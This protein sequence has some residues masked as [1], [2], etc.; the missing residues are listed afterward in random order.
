VLPSSALRED[1]SETL[2]GSIY[3]YSL[4]D[5]S[6]TTQEHPKSKIF[7][8][9]NN[10]IGMCDLS[11]YKTIV[12]QAIEILQTAVL[13]RCVTAAFTKQKT[14]A[15]LFSGGV[16][17]TLLAA[18]A[19][20][21]L[22]EDYH[23]ELINVAF[24]NPGLHPTDFMVPDRVTGLNAY[25][26]LKNLY[27]R[28]QFVFICVNV[29]YS[30]YSKQKQHIISLMKPNFTAMDL[31]IS[32][33]LWFAAGGIG[34]DCGGNHVKSDSKIVIVGSGAD[35]V[36]GGY[37][38]HR[39]AWIRDGFEALL[40]EIQLDV[41]RISYRNLGRD[42]RCISDRG[43]EARYPFLDESVLAYFMKLP[44]GCKMD[45]NMPRGRG[46]KILLRTILSHMGFSDEVVYLP[47]R[48]I[49][50]GAR[51]AKLDGPCKGADKIV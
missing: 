29:S 5:G 16:D 48:A 18:L 49:Q 15:I 27:G 47:K 51:T 8:L 35:E 20:D 30:E 1:W 45:F 23:I 22:P 46:D 26:E 14:V 21:Y 33:A 39:T 13:K 50:F 41:D 17:S 28:R 3:T 9:Q 24:A 38:R 4:E 32:A 7:L 11:D 40:N 34:F 36:N 2:A 31:S 12:N 10:N 42:D 19:A 37:S 43:K 6:L 44:L 25:A